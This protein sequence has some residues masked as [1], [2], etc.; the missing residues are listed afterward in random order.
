M[1]DWKQLEKD[2]EN[3]TPGPWSIHNCESYGDRCKT[4]FKEVWN[5]ETDILVTTEVTRAYTDGGTTNIRRIA[6]VPDLEALAL[7]GRELAAQLKVARNG[8]DALLEL[9]LIPERYRDAAQQQRDEADTTL[10]RWK[11]AGGEDE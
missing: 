3:G 1:M 7:A 11:K 8:F 4:F 5:D 9:D 6:R 10:A 2:R